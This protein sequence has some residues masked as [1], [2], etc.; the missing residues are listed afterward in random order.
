MQLAQH[1][2]VIAQPPG[3]T[4]RRAMIVGSV[5]LLHVA[6]IYALVTGMA[7][8]VLKFVEPPIQVTLVETP[9][10]KTPPVPPKPPLANPTRVQIPTNTVPEPVIKIVDD[11]QSPID[12]FVK[13]PTTVLPVDSGVASVGST[14]STPPYPVTARALSHEGAVLLQMVVSSQGDVA[15]ANVVQSSGFPELDQAAVSWVIAHWKYKPALQAGVAVS[16][17]TQALVKF[18]LKQAQR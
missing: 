10:V 6:V 1:R 5:G 11:T 3:M 18:D 2:M 16:S 13:P 9:L 8:T 12:V 4:P 15:S 17:Q 14:H 7:G